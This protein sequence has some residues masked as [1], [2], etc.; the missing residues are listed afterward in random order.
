MSTLTDKITGNSNKLSELPDLS[1]LKYLQ[2]LHLKY[3]AFTRLPPTL[4]ALPRLEELELAG[5]QL[6]SLDERILAAL[7]KLRCASCT[8]TLVALSSQSV[9]AQSLH[10]PTVSCA[11]SCCKHR[12][13]CHAPG[14]V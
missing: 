1:A 8:C 7:P 6:T 10:S 2:S 9:Q 3:N 11:T 5:N 13:S 14:E 12:S 4:L